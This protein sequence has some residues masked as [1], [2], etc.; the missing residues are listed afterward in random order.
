[1]N[2]NKKMHYYM[3]AANIVY[4]LDGQEQV[5]MMPI[6]SAVWSEEPDR[7][8][9]LRLISRA[10]QAAQ[11]AF[12]KKLNQINVQIRDVVIVNMIY[13]GHMTE[14][15]FNEAPPGMEL[16]VMAETESDADA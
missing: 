7:L 9:R 3:V 12:I 5:G 1:M 14:A 10:Q 15:Q 2:K 13:L 11:M 16:K 4:G 8:I 6:N